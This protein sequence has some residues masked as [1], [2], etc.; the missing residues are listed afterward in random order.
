MIIAMLKEIN[1]LKDVFLY[2]SNY[3]THLESSSFIDIKVTLYLISLIE[4]PIYSYIT[5]L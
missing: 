1:L 4:I 3:Y 2:S 5:R